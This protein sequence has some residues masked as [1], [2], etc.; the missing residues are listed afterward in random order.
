MAIGALVSGANPHANGGILLRDLRMPDFRDYAV[1]VPLPGVT[2]ISDAH[3]LGRFLVVQDGRLLGLVTPNE[4]RAVEPQA[5]PHTAV[6][7]VMRSA[8]KVHF[9]SRDMPAMEALET[10]GREDVNQLPVMSDGRVEGI[11]SR[12][13]VLQ[14]LRSRAELSL[15]P[16]L[17][18][19]T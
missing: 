1:D 12:A 4:V 11:V 17:P 10:M 8:D 7:N 6:R 19:A 16:S 2:G 3:V 14:V 9:V 5:W 13:H 18:R 15:P